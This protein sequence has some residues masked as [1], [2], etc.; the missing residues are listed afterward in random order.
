MNFKN[1]SS[2]ES[3]G[4]SVSILVFTVSV[5]VLS[6]EITIRLNPAIAKNLKGGIIILYYRIEIA[7]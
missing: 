2:T 6:R 5:S 3:H 7:V 4:T 1:N